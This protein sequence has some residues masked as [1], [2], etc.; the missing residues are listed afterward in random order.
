MAMQSEETLRS[1]MEEELAKASSAQCPLV[2]ACGTVW[3]DADG[4]IIY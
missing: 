2:G 4:W 3:H 1:T